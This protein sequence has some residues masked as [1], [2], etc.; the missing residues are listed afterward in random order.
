[1]APEWLTY[2]M[3]RVD[4]GTDQ[5]KSRQITEQR[6]KRWEGAAGERGGECKENQYLFR[7]YYMEY[8]ICNA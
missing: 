2:G 4:R 7:N 1:M 8:G 3:D 6:W 5:N